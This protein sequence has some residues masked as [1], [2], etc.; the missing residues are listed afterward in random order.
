IGLLALGRDQVALLG[1]YV[2][3]GVVLAHWV[4]GGA[5]SVRQT[6]A[7]LAAAGVVAVVVAAVPVLMTALL[8]ALSNRP[9]IAFWR[10]GQGSL[11]PA[12]LL[13]LGFADLYGAADPNIDYWGPPS[14]IWG[15]TGLFLAQNMGQ[16]YL[17]ALPLV[18]VLGLGIGR[19][20]AWARD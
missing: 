18:A 4:Q 7:P 16:L 8:A 10:A 13:T 6:F 20:L 5:A 17:G 12:H 11:Q 15:P 14:P 3:V 2:V 19:G 9:V 1:L